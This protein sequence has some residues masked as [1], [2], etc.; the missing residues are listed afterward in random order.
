MKYCGYERHSLK[1]VLDMMHPDEVCEIFRHLVDVDER[2]AKYI[3]STLEGEEEEMPAY[4]KLRNRLSEILYYAPQDEDDCDSEVLDAILTDDYSQ[5]D[6]DTYGE[7][8]KPL[9]DALEESLDACDV[10]C[11]FQCILLLV[12][13]LNHAGKWRILAAGEYLNREYLPMKL[14]ETFGSAAPDDRKE[15]MEWVVDVNRSISHSAGYGTLASRFM[16]LLDDRTGLKVLEEIYTRRFLSMSSFDF[17]AFDDLWNV[18][19]KLKDWKR[20]EKLCEEHLDGDMKYRYMGDML[21]GR[22]RYD[23]ALSWYRKYFDCLEAEKDYSSMND[24]LDVMDVYA[25]RFS[26]RETVLEMYMAS[27]DVTIS[28]LRHLQ[29]LYRLTPEEDRKA[30]KERI[31]REYDT[32]PAGYILRAFGTD[33]EIMDEYRKGSYSMDDLGQ[34]CSNLELDSASFSGKPKDIRYFASLVRG[35][36]EGILVYEDVES[37]RYIGDVL[38]I[39]ATKMGKVGR[40]EAEAIVS[41]MP[42]L[43]AFHEEVLERLGTLD[44]FVEFRKSLED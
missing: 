26:D 28:D 16:K 31:L 10:L 22:R 11:G 25:S 7:Y 15:I 18:L 27:L 2:F 35:C 1:S 29:V 8:V 44:W 39:L 12:R 23:D 40:K 6:F 19:L 13:M 9:T 41:D 38:E 24:L 32:L 21:V 4:V 36:L 17:Y 5:L 34:Y 43:T 33:D 14:L 37:T 30:L 3:E 20:L 42:E